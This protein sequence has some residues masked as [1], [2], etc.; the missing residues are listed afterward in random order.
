MATIDRSKAAAL[1][2]EAVASEVSQHMTEASVALS[3]L[4]VLPM[5]NATFRMP[6]LDALPSA[7]FLASDQA[8]KPSS[9]MEWDNKTLTAEEIAVIVPVSETVI[10]DANIDVLASVRERIVEA[11][12]L[13]VDKAV[14]FGT[15]APASW[16]TDGICGAAIDAGR[17]VDA[18]VSTGTLQDDLNELFGIVELGGADVNHVAAGRAFRASLRGIQAGTAGGNVYQPTEGNPNLGTVYGAPVAYPLGWDSATALAVAYDRT[19]AVIGL[20]SDVQVK[21]LTEATITGFGNLA[22]KDSVAVR[23]TMRVGFQLADPVSIHT[24]ER[25]FPAA[26]Y[27]P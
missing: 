10:A 14:Y 27:I 21:L 24:G 2:E 4:P 8:V 18:S 16:P 9:E 6:I 26:A 22:E 12:G 1:F 7:G 5:G 20:R 25:F 17:I 19:K 3:T 23:A 15:G 13:I 11:F